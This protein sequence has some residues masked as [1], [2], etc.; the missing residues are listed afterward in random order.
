MPLKY[1]R[2]AVRYYQKTVNIDLDYARVYNNMGKAYLHLDSKE[3]FDCFIKAEKLG[4]EEAQN[5]FRINNIHLEDKIEVI[6]TKK[7][8]VKGKS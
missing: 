8:K 5:F 1:Y 2:E 3:C 7:W 4:D 6:N